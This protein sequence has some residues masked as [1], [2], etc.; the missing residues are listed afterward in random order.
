MSLGNIIVV[1]QQKQLINKVKDFNIFQ[2]KFEDLC[3]FFK[4][5]EHKKYII[6]FENKIHFFGEDK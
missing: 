2:K 3:G 4:N 6:T 5:K 1:L